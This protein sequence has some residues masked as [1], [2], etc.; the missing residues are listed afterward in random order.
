[1][2]VL[3]TVKPGVEVE[4]TAWRPRRAGPALY[5]VRTKDGGKEGW[6]SATHL[7]HRPK[8]PPPRTV[9]PAPPVP[10][11]GVKRVTAKAPKR[12]RKGAR[13]R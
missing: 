1:V 10:S 7:E 9:R 2:T 11:P 6:V 8:P 3:A 5:R 4:I 12:P 13:A